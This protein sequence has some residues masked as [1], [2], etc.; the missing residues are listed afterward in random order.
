LI[1]TKLCEMLGMKYPIMQAAMGPYDTMDLAIAV[2]NAGGF[3]NV[4]HPAPSEEMMADLLA[5]QNLQAVF[6]SVK[7][8]MGD[9]LSKVKSEADGHFGL[10]LR[11]APEQPEVPGL[12]DM[13]I[14]MRESDPELN[15]KLVLIITSAGDPAQPHLQ[16]IKQAGMTWFHNVPS[17]YHARKAE[18]AG[19]DGLIA[20]GYE[21]GG[22]VTFFPVHTMVLVPEVV[23]AVN[24]P[25]VGGGGI[26]DGKGLVAAL[27]FGTVG[28]YMGTRFIATQE[29]EFSRKSKE[30]IITGAERFGKEN[31]TLVTQ[32]FFG[33]LRHMRN[34][35]S[36]ELARLKDGGASEVEMLKFEIK[37]SQ[38]AFG[39]TEDIEN[40]A[41]W[42]GQVAI[43]LEDIPTA[44]EVIERIM[45]EAEETLKELS[46]SYL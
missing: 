5:G 7:E 15:E 21:A 39:P 46:D 4:S 31:A 33:P 6:D 22:H 11:V 35:F 28:I 36:E 29:S 16:K 8:K 1:E 24:V 12:L 26:C 30:T 38:L 44:A 41:L 13:I 27:A 10:N 34:K 37:G 43:R 42:C 32:G 25:V 3:G 20:T 2:T 19:V 18:Q 9:A 14:E 17:V 23:K 40:G 45:S